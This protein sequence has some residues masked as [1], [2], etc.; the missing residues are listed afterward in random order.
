MVDNIIVDI[1][2]EFIFHDEF[3][4]SLLAI[5]NYYVIIIP[6][7]KTIYMLNI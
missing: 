2:L 7:S 1:S 6:N 3:V 4:F 5:S